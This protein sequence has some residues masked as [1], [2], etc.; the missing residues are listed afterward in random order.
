VAERY[1]DKGIGLFDGRGR[2]TG[3]RTYAEVLA[4]AEG[5]AARLAVSGVRPRDRVLVCLPTSWDLL[6]AWFGALL[7]GAWPVALAPAP[8][9]ASVSHAAKIAKLVEQVEARLLLTGQNLRGRVATPALTVPELRELSP[10]TSFAPARPEPDEIAFMQMTSGSTGLPR[11]VMITHHAV[12]HNNAASNRAI[13]APFDGPTSSW[14]DAVVA[15]LPLNHDMGLVGCLWMALSTGLDL[16]LLNPSAFLSRPLRWLQELAAHGRAIAPAPNFGYQLCVERIDPGEL[17]GLDLSGW[18]AALTGA[19]MIRPE[20]VAAFNELVGRCGMRPEMTRPCYGMA[21]GTLAVTFDGRGEGLRTL[22]VPAGAGPDVEISEVACVG[23]PIEDTVVQVTAP[24]GA[25]MPSGE[26]GEVWVRGP[27]VFSGYFNDSEATAESL[28]DGWL[29]TG[30][31][32]FL[33]DDELYLTGRLKDVL[34]I[35][36]NNIMPHELEWLAESVAGGGGSMRCG[37]FSVSRGAEGEQAVLVVE[38]TAKEPGTR[39]EIEREIRRRIGETLALP[40]A[41]VLFVRRGQIAKTTSGK[42]QRKELRRRYIAGRLERLE[43]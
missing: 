9:G 20:T 41:D 23:S 3:R 14:G 16:W 42:V 8:M 33:H 19:E 11:A 12:I 15:W 32:G 37:A 22:P 40:L 36:G 6:D 35:R 13:G 43:E 18:R 31:L 1:P 26:I 2:A 7:V 4:A 28:D 27:G 5:L 24:N 30:D 25:K 21:E 10:P 17:D 38:T 29:R 34:I 39:A